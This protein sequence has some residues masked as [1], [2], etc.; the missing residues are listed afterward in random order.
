MT[1]TLE[2]SSFLKLQINDL[3]NENYWL[4]LLLSKVIDTGLNK[5]LEAEIRRRIQ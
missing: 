5:E 4:K 3:Q 2:E 1:P